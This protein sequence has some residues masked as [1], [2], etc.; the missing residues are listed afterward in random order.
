[1]LG[2]GGPPHAAAPARLRVICVFDGR[3][4]GDPLHRALRNPELSCN[5]FRGLPGLEQGVYGMSVDHPGASS[6]PPA[7]G[8][9]VPCGTAEN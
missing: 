7:A 3:L 6:P 2:Q 8:S 1:L 4:P 5:L 9:E